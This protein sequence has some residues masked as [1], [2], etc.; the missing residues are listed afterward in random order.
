MKLMAVFFMQF[1]NANAER[2]AIENPVGFMNSA[3]RQADQ[4]ISPYMFAESEND[5]KNYV[6]KATCL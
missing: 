2:I 4:T 3:L 1:F 6:T 5:E